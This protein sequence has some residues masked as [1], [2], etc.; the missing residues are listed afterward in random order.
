MIGRL[1]ALALAAPLAACGDPVEADAPAPAGGGPALLV[2]PELPAGPA[3][4]PL[5]PRAAPLETALVDELA[6][7]VERE[8]ARAVEEASRLS[9]GVANASTVSVA[10]CVRDAGA[11]RTIVDRLADLSLLPASNMKLVTAAAA[12]V[13][14][15]PGA[16]FETPVELSGRVTSGVLGGDLVLRA[17]GDPFHD[18]DAEGAVEERIAGPVADA[19]RARGVARIAGDV[20]LDEGTFPDPGPGPGWPP[21]SQHWTESCARSGGFS[22][23]GGL[24]TARVTAGAVGAPAAIDLH[25]VPHGL[26]DNLG[27]TTVAGSVLD[28]RI[29]ATVSAV[30]VKGKL[31]ARVDSWVGS[32]SHPDPVEMFGAVLLGRL[33][34][35]GV[36][37]DGGIRRTRGAPAGERIATLRSPLVGT[38]VAVNTHSVNGVAD[39]VFLAT[40]L[41]ALGDA[42]R[43]GAAR[44]T[45]TA[46]DRLGVPD[47]GLVQVDGSGLSRDDR[48]TARQVAALVEAALELEDAEA[49]EA[50]LGSLA[51]AGR[52]GTLEKRMGGTVAEGVVRAKTGWIRGASALSGATRTRDGRV[53]V[54]SILVGYPRQLPGLNDKCFKPMHDAIAVLLTELGA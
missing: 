27:V 3:R 47:E 17:G 16:Q 34:E 49:R 39:Q 41:R 46:L 28:V 14:L 24:L 7:A 36:E 37:V 20:V 45:A 54:F 13:L 22:V 42:S 33:R 40:G 12:L 26:R 50:F 9:N 53:L 35:A 29:G 1:T 32:F 2:A 15:G 21:A 44:A 5:V 18:L 31:G 52:T 38:L 43:A 8:I 30:T 48:V 4:P 23:N 11:D 10:V 51:V 6:V 19:L 25:P